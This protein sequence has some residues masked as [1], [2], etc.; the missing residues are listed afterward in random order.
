MANRPYVAIALAVWMIWAAFVGLSVSG[1]PP[2][3]VGGGVFGPGNDP[4]PGPANPAN[5]A[6]M[7]FYSVSQP[8]HTLLAGADSFTAADGANPALFG[9]DVGASWNWIDGDQVF[10]VVETRRGVNGWTGTNH[11]TSIPGTLRPGFTVQD[12]GNGVLEALP[13]VTL[14]AGADY[15]NAQWPALTSTNITSYHVW[16]SASPAGPWA[17]LT[18]VNQGPTPSHNDTGLSTG[19]HCYALGINYRRDTTGGV[20]EPLGRTEPRCATVTGAS[21][22]ILVTN[23]AD[24]SPNVAVNSPIVV[25]F[26]EAINTVTF[27]WTINPNIVLVPTWS[28]GNTVVTL[29]HAMDFTQCTPQYVVTIVTAQDVDNNNLVPGPVPNPFDFSTFCPSPQ[30]VSTTPVDGAAAVPRGTSIVITFSKQIATASFAYTSSPGLTGA[31]APVWSGGDTVVTIAH[32]GFSSGTV[33]T[34]TVT[35]AQDMLGNALVPGPV[36]NPFDFTA[37]TPPTGQLTAPVVP[38]LCV[39]GGTSLDITWTMGDTETTRINLHVWINY[40]DGVNTVPIPGA[41]DLQT[42]NSPETFTWPTPGTLDA[43]VTILLTIRDGAGESVQ[44]TSASVRVDSTRPTVTL[45]TPL[46][47]ATN[48]ATDSTIVLTF[49]EAMD[50]TSAQ[51]AVSFNPGVAGLTFTWTVGDTV[52]TV[53]HPQLTINQPYT[54]TVGVGARDACSPGLTLASGYTANFQTGAGP[55]LPNPPTGLTVT[56]NTATAI[57]FS[58]TAPTQYTD[59]SS[60]NAADIDEYRVYRST[61]TDPLT[62]TVIGTST[63]PTVSFTDSNVAAGTQYYYWVKTVLLS[64]AE[65]DFSDPSLPVRAGP[66]PE[67]GFNWLVVIIPLIVILLLVGAFLLMRRKKPAAPPPRTGAKAAARMEPEETKPAEDMESQP[68]E[69]AGGEEK[70]IPCPNCG[71][72][73]KPTDAEC[74]VCGAKL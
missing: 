73:V 46:P 14:T 6:G 10:V 12:L 64:G 35:S 74:F 56:S 33:Y 52:L 22:R 51:A 31:L 53:G 66:L 27:A 60:L 29:N 47:G 62:A 43:D 48:V 45:T 16:T 21:P 38:G 36:P 44:D 32:S 1:S 37:N 24:G 59:G 8:S 2:H 40:T 5:A 54:I 42:P 9:K 39:T 68:R 70:F 3:V 28:G 57:S 25:T 63:S 71:T 23:P 34:V 15:V 17:S 13:T 65:S 72:M 4:S 58:W 26:S 11:T 30:I 69:D 20:Y 50:T 49:S 7:V 41:Q 18:T 61:S 67:P 19:Q 55:R